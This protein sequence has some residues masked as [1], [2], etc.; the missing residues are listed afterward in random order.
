MKDIFQTNNFFSY[1][2]PL[3]IAA[4]RNNPL[5]LQTFIE[6]YGIKDYAFKDCLTLE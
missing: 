2:T 5:V 3:Q 4:E 1:M 6:I